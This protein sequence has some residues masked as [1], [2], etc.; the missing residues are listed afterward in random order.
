MQV[1]RG[2]DWRTGRI[3]CASQCVTGNLLQFE[4]QISELETIAPGILW[5]LAK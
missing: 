2:S 3:A 4:L 1:L 5:L